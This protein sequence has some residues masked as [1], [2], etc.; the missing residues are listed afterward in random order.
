MIWRE[1][2]D[3]WESGSGLAG[4]RRS[5]SAGAAPDP[6]RRG[7]PPIDDTRALGSRATSRATTGCSR[8]PGAPV[9]DVSRFDHTE[10]RTGGRV[11]R[12][13]RRQPCVVKPAVDTGAGTASPPGPHA[14]PPARATLRGS[15]PA[16]GLLIEEAGGGDDYRILVLDGVVLDVVRRHPPSVAGDGRSTVARLLAVRTAGAWPAIRSSGCGCSPSTSTASSRSSARASGCDRSPRPGRRVVL[17]GAV[18]Q[19][20]AEENETVAGAA[21]RTMCARRRLTLRG[22]SGCGSPVSMSS[23]PDPGAGGAGEPGGPRGEPPPGPPSSLRRR[24]PGA[25]DPGRSAYPSR[26][27]ERA[28][29][30]G[31]RGERRPVR[32]FNFDPSE[33]RERYAAD[34]FVHVPDGVTPE[35]LEAMREFVAR[36]LGSRKVEGKADRGGQG[37]GDLRVPGGR[38]TSPARCSTWSPSSATSIGDGMTLSERHVKAYFDDAAPEPTAHKDRYSSQIS[39]GLSIDTP[40]GSKVVLYPED[41]R[42]VNPFNVSGALI[43]SLPPERHPDQALRGA[44]EVEIDDRPGDVVAFPGS[45]VWHLRRKPA[46]AVI[47]YLKLNDFNSDPLGEDPAT[48]GRRDA[49]LAALSNGALDAR[50]PVPSRRLDTDH[51]SLPQGRLAGGH[52][53]RR[54]GAAA[55]AARRT[56]AGAAPSDGRSANRGRAAGRRISAACGRGRHR[57]GSSLSAK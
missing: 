54:V 10:R 40:P 13:R 42:D 52:R 7:H 8:K 25:R 46:G 15:R 3:G 33:L 24:R 31:A 38:P 45:S 50:V 34:Q 47:L 35:F 23:S 16:T 41:D 6:V 51:P 57:C 55:A 12:C 14:G 5:S 4:R 17:K 18:N 32:I 37:P 22:P 30:P 43:R 56:R 53:G 11:P 48:P 26:L 20:A 9:P 1:A 29:G 2:A 19:N 39:V 44:R 36:S 49:T 27:V 28:R 21:R